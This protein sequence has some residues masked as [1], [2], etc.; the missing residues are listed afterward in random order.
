MEGSGELLT[1]KIMVNGVKKYLFVNVSCPAD[2]FKAE[3]LDAAGNVVKGYSME[4]C[5]AVGGDD[6]CLQ[7]TWKNGNDLS[8]L[9]GTDFQI[10]FSMN[11][12][13]EFYSFWL[14]DSPRGESGGAIGAGYV[15]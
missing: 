4:D 6:T 3:I 14:S 7:I 12:S 11:Q 15:Q 2:S 1:R 9:N 8:F 5:V 10:R 13:G